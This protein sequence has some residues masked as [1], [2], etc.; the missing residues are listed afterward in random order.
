MHGQARPLRTGYGKIDFAGCTTFSSRVSLVE[1]NLIHVLHLN[2]FASG[3]GIG[4]TFAEG[5]TDGILGNLRGT[6]FHEIN[7]LQFIYCKGTYLGGQ[8]PALVKFHQPPH[9]ANYGITEVLK[10]SIKCVIF[11]HCS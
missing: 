10:Y 1:R 11:S 3:Q 6:S 9:L 2:R 8:K 5:R 7:I 4:V